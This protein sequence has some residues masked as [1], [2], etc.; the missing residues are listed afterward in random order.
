MN[1]SII[2][3]EFFVLFIDDDCMDLSDTY[4]Y[5]KVALLTLSGDGSLTPTHFWASL[6]PHT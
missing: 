3:V 6:I 4:G 2:S 1:N 5:P